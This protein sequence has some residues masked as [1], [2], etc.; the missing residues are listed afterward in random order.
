MA[1]LRVFL[2]VLLFVGFSCG[3]SGVITEPNDGKAVG[4]TI[5]VMTKTG[6]HPVW[7]SAE[8]VRRDEER[9]RDEVR[10]NVAGC[11]A[12]DPFSCGLAAVAYRTGRGVAADGRQ[13]A[14]LQQRAVIGYGRQCERGD[15][16]ACSVFAFAYETGEGVPRDA[17]RSASLYHRARDL[18]ETRCQADDA[19]ACRRLGDLVGMWTPVRDYRRRAPLYRKALALFEQHCARGS[20]E[21]CTSAAV[22][23][24]QGEGA[25]AQ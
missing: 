16:V 13:A 18:D 8:E 12:G 4:H 10:R 5:F 15:T 22:M 14:I 7:V 23:R 2:V 20:T 25:D 9:A 17:G 21:G 3:H 19:Q 24:Q 6:C 11:E 1:G